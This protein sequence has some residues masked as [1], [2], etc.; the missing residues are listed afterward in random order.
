M[1]MLCNIWSPYSGK[2]IQGL[3]SNQS[4]VHVPDVGGQFPL[5]VD[6]APDDDVLSGDVLRR[7]DLRLEAEC[8]NF[9]RRIRP[10]RLHIDSSQPAIAKLLH[11]AV[12]EALDSL[13]T[14]NHLASGRKDVGILGVQLS[15]GMRIALVE[16]SA[17]LVVQ[18]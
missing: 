8:A 3:R 9:A 18:L 2:S 15:Q 7:I 10:E 11:R 1:A 14:V 5:V 4:L 12:P 6:L 13:P 17:P 16:G